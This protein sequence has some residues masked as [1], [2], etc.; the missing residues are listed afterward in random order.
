MRCSGAEES[1]RPLHPPPR[2]TR[3]QMQWGFRCPLSKCISLPL[4]GSDRSAPGVYEATGFSFSSKCSGVTSVIRSALFQVHLSVISILPWVPSTQVKSPVTIQLAP[5]P[6]P[7]PS[8]FSLWY[9]P[10]GGLCLGAFVC[11]F[12]FVHWLLSVLTPTYE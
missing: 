5:F 2:G 6:F 9:P 10:H 3:Y 12:F 4:Q 8:S 11:L 7:T 1:L